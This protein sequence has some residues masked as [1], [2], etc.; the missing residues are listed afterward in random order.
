[1]EDLGSTNG[2]LVND[3]PIDGPRQLHNGDQ[4]RFGSSIFKF[5]AGG[6]VE[7][8]YHE[9][10]YRL[11]ITDGLT[12]A[13]TQRAFLEFL[14]REL[15]RAK[16]HARPLSLVMLDIDRFKEVNDRHGHLAGDDVLRGVA[17][18]I[19]EEVRGDELFARYGGEEFAVVLPETVLEDAA[20]FCERVRAKVE[21]Q[22]FAWKEHVLHVTISVGGTS[23]AARRGPGGASGARRRPP[24]RGETGRPQLLRP[25]L[26]TMPYPSAPWAFGR[27]PASPARERGGIVPLRAFWPGRPWRAPPSRHSPSRRERRFATAPR[28]QA[29]WPSRPRS[30][31]CRSCARGSPRGS[32]RSSMPRPRRGPGSRA[33]SPR[34]TMAQAELR[35]LAYHDDLTG[36]PN[37]SLLYDRLGLAL[38]HAEREGSR[39]AV[40][41]VD[42]D[43][44]KAVNDCFGH[45]FGDRF[46]VELATRLRASVRAGDTVARFGGDEFVVLLNSVTGAE[47]AALVAAKVR[48]AVEAPFLRDGHTVEV[49]ASVGI[50]VYPGDGASPEALVKRA[51]ADM[52]R[53]KPRP[54]PVQESAAPRRSRWDARL[55]WRASTRGVRDEGVPVLAIRPRPHDDQRATAGLRPLRDARDA[56]GLRQDARLGRA[57]QGRGSRL[58]G[59]TRSGRLSA[60]RAGTRSARRRRPSWRRWSGA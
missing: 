57:G 4:L 48:G 44:F 9:E 19:R 27:L 2:T 28:A 60:A 18:A 40:L 26:S 41:F 56:E 58:Q 49:V 5:I 36:L 15:L 55:S 31:W 7:A 52:Y 39:L 24:V 45:D 13:A 37:R 47:D 21:T 38:A 22:T 20:R 23:T 11:M 54:A 42:L 43:G 30:S 12:G 50:G 34:L 59:V 16:R 33:S 29:P 6:N 25:V 53:D 14:D 35:N 3:E 17:A 46:L 10:I 32:W 1:M 8:L 51:D